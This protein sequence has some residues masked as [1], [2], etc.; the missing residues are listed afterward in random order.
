MQ[1][2]EQ[3]GVAVPKRAEQGSPKVLLPLSLEPVERR[4]ENQV[5]SLGIGPLAEEPSPEFDLADSTV[6]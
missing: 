6:W 4:L 5:R 3:V 2:V 1:G